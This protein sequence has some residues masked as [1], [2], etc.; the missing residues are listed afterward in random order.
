MAFTMC[1]QCAFAKI[2]II[3]KINEKIISACDI[4]FG[5]YFLS[6]QASLYCIDFVSA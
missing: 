6:F 3:N 5:I 1:E 4:L 2:V